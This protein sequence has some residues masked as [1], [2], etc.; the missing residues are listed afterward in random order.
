M[1]LLMLGHSGVGKTT[2]MASMYGTM[3]FPLNG[4]T[5]RAIDA[6]AHVRLITI[7]R[8]ILA[9]TY[10]EITDQ[11]SEYQFVLVYEGE[12]FF[13]FSWID[14]RG[15]ALT[16]SSGTLEGASL[17]KDLQSADGIIMFCDATALAQRSSV[18]KQLG[19]MATL[20]TKSFQDLTFPKP[21]T[22]VFTKCDLIQQVDPALVQP[23]QALLDAA[24]ANQH[25]Y[26]RYVFTACG[27]EMIGVEVPVLHS[28]YVGTMSLVQVLTALVEQSRA[29]EERHQL[30]VRR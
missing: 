30:L 4:F 3:Q 8:G 6:S 11:R 24:R 25:V 29:Q 23:V 22:V 18:S 1:K 5:L 9:G 19:R 15:G 27:P 20:L 10:P 17:V 13:P 2:Y 12:D 26:G 21:L 14:Y 28:V 16:E 7:C